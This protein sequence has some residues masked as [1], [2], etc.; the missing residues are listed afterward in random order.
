MAS[1]NPQER[2]ALPR[3]PDDV[4]SFAMRPFLPAAPRPESA[5]HA[6]LAHP[7]TEPDPVAPFLLLQIQ[8]EYEECPGLS[9]TIEEGARF[10][11]LDLET[12]ARVLATLAARGFLRRTTNGRYEPRPAV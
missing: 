10:W 2:P 4:P 12:C 11:G 3:E 7:G 8:G 1:R 5:A 9:V 6:R